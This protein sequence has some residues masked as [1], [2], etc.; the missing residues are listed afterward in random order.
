MAKVK[1]F[2]TPF[3]APLDRMPYVRNSPT[4]FAK[5]NIISRHERR[6]DIFSEK[7]SHQRSMWGGGGGGAKKFEKKFY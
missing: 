5:C 1:Q 6:L 2:Y 4:D 3:V 7:G